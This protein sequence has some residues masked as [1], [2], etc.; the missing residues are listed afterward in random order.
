MASAQ[1]QSLLA[2]IRA[3]PSRADLG[4]QQLRDQLEEQARA[5]PPAAD[6]RCRPVEAG[7]VPCEWVLAPG[8]TER[9][10]RDGS[11]TAERGVV[12]YLHGGGYY[13]GSLHTHRELCSRISRAGGWAVLSVGYRLAPEHPFPAALEDALAAYRW[14]LGTGIAPGQIVVAGDS[15]GGGLAAALMLALRDG[16]TSLR[17]AR[18]PL[19]GGAVLLS[20]WTDLEQSGA[21]IIGRA[22]ADPSL[23]KAYLDRFAAAYLGG[24]D[25]RDPLASPLHGDLRGLPPLLI[26]VGTAEILEDDAARFADKA[27][28]AGVPVRLE[29][30]PDMIHVWQRYAALLPEAQEALAH[31]G[32]WPR[33]RER[34]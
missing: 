13:R 14:L 29:R 21:S 17:M 16:V 20:P 11:N 23:T 32:A 6:V 30:W 1:M 24:A 18:G 9:L 31:I 28:A 4:L 3:A 5:A 25:A 33:E 8:A 27:Q 2:T 10:P 34:V 7:G 15:A 26:Q 19:P 12:L 22:A